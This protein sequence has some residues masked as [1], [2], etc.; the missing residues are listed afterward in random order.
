MGFFENTRKPQGFGGKIMVKMM[1]IGHS[2]LAKWGFTKIY[3]KSNAKV[4]DI[5]CGGGANIVNWLG[6]CA[7]GHVTGID[8]SKVSVEESKKLNAVAINQGKCDIVYGDVSSMSF[9]D[10]AFDCVSA[11]E[12]VY[13]WEDLEKCFAEVHRVMKNGGTFLI[14]NESDGTNFKDEKWA[15]KIGGMK[16]YN[17]T[18]L[19]TMLE[20]VGFCDIK[21]FVDA[22]KHWLCIVANK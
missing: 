7:T 17:E 11:F 20:K 1:N 22:K 15:K 18:Q 4:L 14:C 21:S 10:E 5:G 13:F 2:K 8:Y 6:K 12:T 9:D 16:I 3:A 19:R